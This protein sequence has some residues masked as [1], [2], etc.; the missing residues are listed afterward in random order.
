MNIAMATKMPKKTKMKPGES[1][2]F[3]L[4]KSQLTIFSGILHIVVD[5]TEYKL[6]KHI[7]IVKDEQ[8][9]LTLKE[10]LKDYITGNVAVAWKKGQPIWIKVS[11]A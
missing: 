11:K 1:T 10:L 7:N 5:F 3:Q 6:R 8:Q 9:K 4:H 2:D